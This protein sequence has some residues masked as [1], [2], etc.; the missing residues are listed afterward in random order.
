MWLGFLNT[1]MCAR[2][3]V[4]HIKR[5]LD[6]LFNLFHLYQNHLN[7]YWSI[8]WGLYLI[9]RLAIHIYLLL[10]KLCFVTMKIV[11]NWVELCVY[12]LVIQLHI[13]KGQ[14]LR[15]KLTIS[16]RLAFLKSSKLRGSNCMSRQFA[17]VL[18]QLEIIHNFKVK[19]PLKDST[20]FPVLKCLPGQNYL[21]K[22]QN[23]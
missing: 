7:T 16:L 13:L 10:C 22:L 15:L 18:K 1:V 17:Q 2:L 8:V 5:F 23:I 20:K 11:K 4:K 19:V 3:L 6:P 21:L 14:F 9:P 12:P